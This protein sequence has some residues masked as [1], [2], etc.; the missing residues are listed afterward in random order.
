MQGLDRQ[1]YHENVGEFWSEGYGKYFSN[2]WEIVQKLCYFLHI[3]FVHVFQLYGHNSFLLTFTAIDRIEF[4]LYNISFYRG[5]P[6]LSHVNA[7]I[8]Y[9]K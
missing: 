4:P 1:F 3:E 6:V 8:K 5:L 9:S 2:S 7:P